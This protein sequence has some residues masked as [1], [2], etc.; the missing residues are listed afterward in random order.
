MNSNPS[1][2]PACRPSAPAG[3]S[4]RGEAAGSG[5]GPAVPGVQGPWRSCAR[6]PAAVRLPAGQT[7]G[8]ADP[9]SQLPPPDK[10]AAG[11][12][13]G[14]HVAEGAAARLDRLLEIQGGIEG[15]HSEEI[16]QK[17]F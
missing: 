15:L 3:G 6:G 10:A 11:T 1:L 13:D 4:L 12:L 7:D 8:A 2:S 16:Q 17:L 5:P 9:P 14:S